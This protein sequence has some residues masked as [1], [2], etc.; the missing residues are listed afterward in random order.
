M[1][2]LIEKDEKEEEEKK[3]K[4]SLLEKKEMVE[5]SKLQEQHRIEREEM[6]NELGTVAERRRRQ[7]L[8]NNLCYIIF[9]Y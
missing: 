2:K 7:L 4:R 9:L 1:K 6:N 8:Q 5:I 3:L